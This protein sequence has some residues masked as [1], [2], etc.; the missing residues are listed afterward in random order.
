[1]VDPQHAVLQCYFE[2]ADLLRR[3]FATDPR[4]LKYYV[5][6]DSLQLPPYEIRKIVERKKEGIIPNTFGTVVQDFTEIDFLDRREVDDNAYKPEH[7]KVRV[8]AKQDLVFGSLC[9]FVQ[10]FAEIGGFDAIINLFTFS[11]DLSQVMPAE[12]TK[13]E[14]ASAKKEKEA[15]RIRIPFG[16]ITHLTKPFTHLDATFTAEFA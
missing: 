2:F 11:A 8:Q 1:M 16:M 4:T 14:S 13:Q 15:H 7:S 3:L 9:N 10:Y 5:L 6:N 12:E